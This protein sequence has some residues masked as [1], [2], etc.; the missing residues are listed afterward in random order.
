[1]PGGR[2]PDRAFTLAELLVVIAIIGLLGALLV[3]A[4][5]SAVGFAHQTACQNNLHHVGLA[6]HN[7]ASHNNGAIPFGPKAPPMMTAADFY[8][9]TGAPTSLISLMNGKPVGLGLLLQYDLAQEPKVLFCPGSDQSMSADNE[10]ANVGHHQA[11]CSYYYRHA[12]VDRQYDSGPNVMSP[13]HIQL[14][15]LGLNRNGKPIRALVMDTQFLVPSGFQSFGI[16]SRTHHLRRCTN[17]LFADGHVAALDNTD[18]RLTV[19]LDNYQALTHAFDTILAVME[20]A[21][22]EF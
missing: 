15:N 3:P 9:S 7:Y 22:E 14:E 17:V 19:N 8:P 6:I 5:A 11:Q 1:M 13:D 2:R 18:G 10:L 20:V 16:T 4:L 21:D 12:S